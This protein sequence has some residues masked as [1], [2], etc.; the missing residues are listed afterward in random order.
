MLNS[1]IVLSH[2]SG[3]LH[4]RQIVGPLSPI[5][6]SHKEPVIWSIGDFFFVIVSKAFYKQSRYRYL[7][8]HDAHV[9]S[10]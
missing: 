6:V 5:Y 4:R 1:H 2:V 3:N 9:T 7:G 10:L 8:R